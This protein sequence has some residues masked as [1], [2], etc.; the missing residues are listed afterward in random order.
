MEFLGLI[1]KRP[2]YDPFFAEN[3]F[4]PADESVFMGLVVQSCN[5]DVT[6]CAEARQLENYHRYGLMLGN[7]ASENRFVL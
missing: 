7:L 2:G 6:A 3:P 4:S 1:N 5:F